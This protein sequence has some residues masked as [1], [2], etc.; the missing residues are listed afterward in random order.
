ML[1]SCPQPS[2]AP[3]LPLTQNSHNLTDR[4]LTMTVLDDLPFETFLNIFS[5][6]STTDLASAS[7]VCQRWHVICEP[8]LYREPDIYRAPSSSNSWREPRGIELFLRTL[9]VPGCERL[10]SHVRG[11]YLQWWETVVELTPR[12]RSNLAI[13]AG[14]ES[15]FGVTH[16]S[17]FGSPDSQVVLLM[18]LL[19]RLQRL[20]LK[21]PRNRD[22]FNDFLD[23]IDRTQPL[24]LSFRSLTNFYCDW[25]DTDTG[26]SPQAV[27]AL[28]QLPHMD[29]L[30][31]NMKGEFGGPFPANARGT[32]GVT[33]LTLGDCEISTTLVGFILSVP[34]ALHHLQCYGEYKPGFAG[35][36]WQLRA[37]L[38]HLHLGFWGAESEPV[39]RLSLREWP[40]LRDVACPLE[41][42]LGCRGVREAWQL[43]ERLPVCIRQL[44]M[45]YFEF[46][47]EEEGEYDSEEEEYRSVL[48][49]VDLFVQLVSKEKHMVPRLEKLSILLQGTE[50]P[51]RLRAACEIAGVVVSG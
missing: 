50:M 20:E 3:E 23:A 48:N 31:V 2:A 25:C 15:R 32:S 43:A 51:E 4:P 28:L 22:A 13:I 47:M 17:L 27:L 24:P 9:L 26:V 46:N 33:R 18:H 40:V 29:R 5:S 34:R 41:L 14:A 12:R 19:P 35:V 8:I 30:H 38:T 45:L 49:E 39:E 11:I 44:Q 7:L 42:L 21:P 36:L 37:T 6:L 1:P 10:A 16:S